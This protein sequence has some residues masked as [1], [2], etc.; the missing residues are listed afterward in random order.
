MAIDSHFIEFSKPFIDATKN[1]FETMIFSKLENQKPS[2]KIDSSINGDITSFINM[3]G[4]ID[5]DGKKLPFQA[6]LVISFPYE[7]YFKIAEA[8]LGES[9]TSYSPEIKDLGSEIV[10]MVMGNA[11]KEL[12]PLG[13]TSSMAIPEIFEGKNSPINYP[14]SKRIILIP[15]DSTHGSFFMELCYQEK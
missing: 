10:N 12:T 3:N 14:N 1:I 8:M 4:E 9:Y 2:L 15:F 11:K 5:K 7:T 13:Y 6:I